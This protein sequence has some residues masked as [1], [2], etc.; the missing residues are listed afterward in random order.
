MEF[1]NV[2]EMGSGEWAVVIFPGPLQI[3]ADTLTLRAERQSARMSK[4]QMT[5]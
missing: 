3:A 2:L 5:A 4:L 1:G